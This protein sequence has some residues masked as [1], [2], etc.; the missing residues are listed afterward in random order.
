MLF[1]MPA[2][3]VIYFR[4]LGFSLFQISL[5]MAMMPLF[6]LLFEIPT[7]AIADIYGR[8]FSVILSYIIQGFAYILIFFLDNF[9]AL[10]FAFALIGFGSTFI[11]GAKEAWVTDLINKDRKTFLHNYFV[12]RDSLCSAGLVVSGILGAFLVKQYGVAIMWIAAG[13]SFFIS[14]LLLMLA[15]EHFIRRKPKI[16][17]SFK[18]VNKQTIISLKYVRNHNVLFLF[19]IA[20]SLLFFAGAFSGSLSWISFFQSLKFP[21]YAFGYLWSSINILGIFAPFVS[22]KLMKK[23]KERKFLIISVLLGM[24]ALSMILF[25]DIISVAFVILISSM[26]FADVSRPVESIYFQKLIKSKLRATVG[27]IRNMLSEI[28]GIVA[29]PLAGLS[30]DYLGARYTIFLSALLIIPSLILLLMIKENRKITE[31]KLI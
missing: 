1:F 19:I 8:K 13:I 22:I 11:S 14:L 23:G 25:A 5:L 31:R 7:G 6:M 24:L 26:F 20:S 21:D 27:S 16:K 30:V 28:V 9:Y 17:D 3:Y 29:L 15:K 4:D 2:F 10:L 18:N 12:K